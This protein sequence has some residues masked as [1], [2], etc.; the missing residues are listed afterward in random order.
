MHRSL[1]ALSWIKDSEG[2]GPGEGC[3]GPA[4]GQQQWDGEM[5]KDGRGVLE[6][7]LTHLDEGGKEKKELRMTQI[8]ASAARW[9]VVSFIEVEAFERD[10]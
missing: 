1:A 10:F 9:V 5:W 8:L 7:A 4:P 3:W 2:W 6:E